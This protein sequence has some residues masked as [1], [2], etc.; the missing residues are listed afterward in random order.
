MNKIY[1]NLFLLLITI[2]IFIYFFYNYKTKEG[3]NPYIRSV[4]RPYMRILN[5]HYE[6]YKTNYGLQPIFNKLRKWNI[7]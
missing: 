2:F 6:F 5:H 4:Y 1:I 7:Y 3:F